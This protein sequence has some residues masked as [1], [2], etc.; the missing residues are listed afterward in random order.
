M[1]IQKGFTISP[2]FFAAILRSK[3]GFTTYI[4]AGIIGL[5]VIVGGVMLVALPK[6]GVE[7]T[8]MMDDSAMMEEK[9]DA[10][11]EGEGRM[12]TDTV[13]ED[14]NVMMQDDDS[15]MM[16]KG[17]MEEVGNRMEENSM[18]EEVLF[19][20][21]VLAGTNSPLLDFTQADYDKAVASKKVVALY[22][23]ANWC[24]TCKAEF[25]KME[26]VFNA[27]DSDDIVGFRVNFNDNETD[28][29]EKALAREF[30]VA[31]QHTKVL[32][33]NGKRVAKSPEGWDEARYTSEITSLLN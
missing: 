16:E 6:E 10:M 1:F 13:I 2:K 19:T 29:D 32:L 11:M 25:P 4:V 14:E 9:G 7:E 5:I 24:P 23:Y 27:F 30:G 26:A 20:G 12:G 31:Y 3:R 28:S 15:A 8:A 22:F 33:K 18:M 21:T 17:T